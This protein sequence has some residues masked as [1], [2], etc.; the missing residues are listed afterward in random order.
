M[1]LCYRS[2]SLLFIVCMLR[3]NIKIFSICSLD[4]IS[5]I[6][7]LLRS[8]IRFHNHVIE[9]SVCRIIVVGSWHEQISSLYA[10]CW[11]PVNSVLVKRI[12]QH[13]KAW[14]VCIFWGSISQKPMCMASFTLNFIK[15]F[16]L[17]FATQR[18]LGLQ[19]S[20]W[21]VKTSGNKSI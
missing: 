16:F 9:L 20:T 4:V 11:A 8:W 1:L 15:F 17:H 2:N 3:F 14:T 13:D 21:G 19:S 18:P 12:W 7:Y 6:H 5:F 10:I